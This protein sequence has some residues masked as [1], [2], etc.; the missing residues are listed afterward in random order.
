M[1]LHIGIVSGKGGVGKSL[2]YSEYV[3]LADGDAVEIGPF[4]DNMINDQKEKVRYL[5]AKTAEG[6]CE[7]F[8]VLI[9]PD[10][11][12]IDVVN[13]DFKGQSLISEKRR[14]VY[15][16]RK[17]APKTLASV[18]CAAGTIDVTKEHK[19]IAMRHGMLK[20]VEAKD[21]QPKTDY[22]LFFNPKTY[23]ACTTE[24]SE[25]TT[26]LSEDTSELPAG[27]KFIPKKIF[28][29][30][31]DC[32][33]AF[34]KALFDCDSHVSKNRLEIQYDTKSKKLV[35]QVAGLLRTRFGICGQI[36][37]S[38]KKASN[39]NM[40]KQRYWRL[41]I[42]GEN[43]SRYNK[44]I[45]FN[46]LKKK[47][48]LESLI[49]C[50]KPNTNVEAFPVGSLACSDYSF[51][52]VEYVREISYDQPY[53]YDF[54]VCEEGGH[55]VHGSGIVVSNTTTAIN[56]GSALNYFDREVTIVDANLSTPN[57]GV[58]LGVPI[59]PINLHHVLQGKNRIEEAMYS[60]P[61]GTK[62]I[63]AGISL[64]D[65]RNTNPEGLGKA[66][67]T[68]EGSTDIVIIDGAAGLGREALATITAA[69]ELIVITNPEI[70][71]LTDALKTIKLSEE[72]G[73]KVIG[74]V[75]TRTKQNNMDLSIKNMESVLEKPI[76]GIIPED[77]A[78]REAQI[79]RDSVVYTHPKSS[80]AIA[81]KKLA[82]NLIGHDYAEEAEQN[83]GILM[84]IM[85]K[86]GLA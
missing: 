58:H 71:S 4:I 74:V 18:G 69:D 66:L 50:K 59:V 72:L 53:V 57:I 22:L 41:N 14:P 54:Q 26:E 75:V 21:L 56:L 24:L 37:N 77:K 23:D 3:S 2:S 49:K 78:V 31:N 80:A 76:I 84:K 20:E 55:F 44:L 16:M 38:L 7:L 34:I 64:D 1:T 61:T 32:V 25:G 30:N 70:T 6:T 60:H 43:A 29:S 52:R 9:P 11:L 47:N 81:Y 46:D 86:I 79:K 42:S 83:N 67:K 51:R 33:S 12:S 13:F 48:R 40:L 19:F 85:R 8:E 35:F 62:I 68:L 10:E 82:A 45:G 17:P 15:L 27:N 63:P 28:A 36:K 65:I 73:K 39:S 5:V